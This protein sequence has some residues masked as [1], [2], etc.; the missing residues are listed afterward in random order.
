MDKLESIKL[1]DGDALVLTKKGR[2]M[3]LRGHAKSDNGVFR[4]LVIGDRISVQRDGLS[5]PCSYHPS[6][7]DRV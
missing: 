1:H 4:C 5:A 3:G 6:F 7:W 2:E